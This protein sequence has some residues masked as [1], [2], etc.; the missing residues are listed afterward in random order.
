MAIS[1]NEIT[2]TWVGKE[3]ETTLR[4]RLCSNYTGDLLAEI[5]SVKLFD[6]KSLLDFFK[7]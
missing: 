5:W 2:E 3:P 7:C 1:F 4:N 6:I